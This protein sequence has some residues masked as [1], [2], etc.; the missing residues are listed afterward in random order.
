ML[1]F[2][3]NCQMDFLS[4]AVADRGH[5][6]AYRVLAS[7]LTLPSHPGTVPPELN[8][9]VRTMALEKYFHGR[10]PENQFKFSHK[11]HHGRDSLS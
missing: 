7:P 6:V 5:N 3:G 2:S 9:R 8:T 4:R 11:T 10:M 1:Y